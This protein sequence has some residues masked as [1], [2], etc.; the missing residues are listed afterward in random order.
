MSICSL[1]FFA[2]RGRSFDIIIRLVA[3][4]RSVFCDDAFS[5]RPPSIFFNFMP[6]LASFHSCSRF[7]SSTAASYATTPD[8]PSRFT[9]KVSRLS[10]RAPVKCVPIPR[11][12]MFYR[13]TCDLF[14]ILLNCHSL[15]LFLT[16]SCRQIAL[17][18]FLFAC[19]IVM[20]T[21]G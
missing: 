17:A 7:L 16:A 8:M 3:A 9:P 21:I 13:P 15:G 14:I 19:G 11:F 1:T 4:L 10:Q 6:S 18:L 5:L 20:L 2:G 12:V